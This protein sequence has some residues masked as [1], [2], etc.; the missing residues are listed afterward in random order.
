MRSKRNDSRTSCVPAS[1]RRSHAPGRPPNSRG[2]LDETL[3][4]CP[5]TEHGRTPNGPSKRGDSVDGRGH[6]SEVY[7]ILLA[8]AGVARGRVIG[9]S[10]ARAAFPAD[11]PVSPKDIL[12]TAYHLLGVD[13]HRTIPDRLGRPVPLVAEGSVVR[14]AAGV[15]GTPHHERRRPNHLSELPRR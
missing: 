3:V 10:D 14:E 9:A 7:S 13:A 8:G 15:K 4:L 2:L 11:R 6:W 1:I 5:S 12:H